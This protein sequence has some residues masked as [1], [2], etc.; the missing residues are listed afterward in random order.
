MSPDAPHRVLVADDVADE[1][2]LVRRALE[3]TGAFEVVAEADNGAAAVE[4][5]A[6]TQ[7]AVA[8][9]DLAMP[10][11]DGLQAIVRIREVSPAT[12]VVVLSSFGRQRMEPTSLDA[13][14]AAYLEKGLDPEHL[15]DGLLS[16]IA[17]AGGP[18]PTPGTPDPFV[19]RTVL[20][21]AL[22]APGIARGFADKT[23]QE[24]H[25]EHLSETVVLLTSELVTNAV[26]HAES[27][28]ELTLQL[29]DGFLRVEV[30]DRSNT[31]PQQRS[32]AL[33][34]PGGRGIA[35]VDA[36]ASAWGTEDAGLGK[37]VWFQVAQDPGVSGAPGT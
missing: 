1:R 5:A 32:P 22:T 9:L 7:P 26:T 10:D 4:L 13:G 29:V 30:Y 35:L 24:W 6:A 14:A 20:T 15:A 11:M 8:L 16:I 2:Y 12:I 18:P 25:L 17:T 23:L 19:A 36:L 33:D 37:V 34:V 27:D 3:R 21:A 28:L 31:D